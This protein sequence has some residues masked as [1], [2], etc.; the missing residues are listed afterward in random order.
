MRFQCALPTLAE[1]DELSSLTMLGLAPT[2]IVLGSIYFATGAN[3]SFGLWSL[4]LASACS[5]RSPDLKSNFP[6]VLPDAPDLPATTR[7]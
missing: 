4:N 6:G 5:A 1:D 3:S 2:D 7:G